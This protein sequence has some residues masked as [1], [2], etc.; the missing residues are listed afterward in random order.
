MPSPM[1]TPSP[2]GDSIYEESQP[3]EQIQRVRSSFQMNIKEI[4]IIQVQAEDVLKDI[5]ITDL[6]ANKVC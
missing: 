5:L 6:Y 2:S 3:L 1:S 4:L